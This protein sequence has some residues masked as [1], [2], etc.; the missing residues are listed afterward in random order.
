MFVR[1]KRKKSEK[2]EGKKKKKKGENRA[3]VVRMR[4]F[5]STFFFFCTNKVL[6][7]SWFF[8]SLSLLFF[9]HSIHS[10]FSSPIQIFIHH[11]FFNR[12]FRNSNQIE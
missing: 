7:L 4:L 10:N 2:K 6:N 1:S 8:L 11:L 3:F 5:L 9:I 12:L